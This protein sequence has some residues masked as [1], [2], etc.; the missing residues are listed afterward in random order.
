MKLGVTQGLVLALCC[1]VC[2]GKAHATTAACPEQTSGQACAADAKLISDVPTGTIDGH[3]ATFTLSADP[4]SGLPIHIFDN[5]VDDSYY[6]LTGRSV[7]FSASHVPAPGD[8]LNA[9]YFVSKGN[10]SPQKQSSA[11]TPPDESDISD[12]LL[13]NAMSRELGRALRSDTAKTAAI[14]EH[15]HREERSSQEGKQFASV[16]MLARE[17]RAAEVRTKRSTAKGADRD[18]SAEG[19]E[20]LGDAYVPSPFEDLSLSGDSE[21]DQLLGSSSGNG[22]RSSGPQGTPSSIRMLADVLRSSE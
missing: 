15:A 13:Q 21:I 10:S 19:V 17:L 4:V 5:G 1:F 20:G 16:T 8:V 14:P 6:T 2:V 18:I 9:F 11:A 12:Q 7:T 3:N 22:T